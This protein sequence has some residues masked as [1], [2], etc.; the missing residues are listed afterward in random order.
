MD[1]DRT[2]S[3]TIPLFPFN[4][5]GRCSDLVRKP[6]TETEEAD[7]ITI[8]FTGLSLQWL[9]RLF[10]LRLLIHF[11]QPS[12]AIRWVRGWNTSCVFWFF[13]FASLFANWWICYGQSFA[14]ES[15]LWF[16]RS[17]KMPWLNNHFLNFNYCLQLFR[18]VLLA[19][20]TQVSTKYVVVHQSTVS[21]K[22]WCLEIIV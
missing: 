12:R 11:H 3:L 15:W 2:K 21:S 4:I 10:F 14:F 5:Q 22:C 6:E 13:I 7:N 9:W 8:D 20:V 18:I 17:I 1:Q 19:K 16:W